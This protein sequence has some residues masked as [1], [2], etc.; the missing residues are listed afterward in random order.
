MTRDHALAEIA[1][2]A[3]ALKAR[4]AAAAYLFGSTARDEAASG[5]DLDLF[6]DIVPDRKFSLI[7]LSGIELFLTDE[8][9]IDVDVT[10]RDGLHPRLKDS[11]EREAVRAF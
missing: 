7:D 10:T 5:S 3:E 6:I 11:I 1:R 9:G 4:G 2:R 8:L